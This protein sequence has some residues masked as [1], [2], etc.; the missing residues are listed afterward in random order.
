MWIPWLMAKVILR[1]FNQMLDI[2]QQNG[3]GV[4]QDK[5]PLEIYSLATLH[6][7]FAH[8]FCHKDEDILGVSFRELLNKKKIAV[9][10][11]SSGTSI[12]FK[13]ILE[14]IEMPNL[15]DSDSVSKESLGKAIANFKS[16]NIDCIFY[17][18][19]I[20]NE[21]IN[22]LAKNNDI[23]FIPLLKD[24][25]IRDMV[26]L[27]PYYSEGEIPSGLYNLGSPVDT[28]AVRA[29]LVAL[30]I[31]QRFSCSLIKSFAEK[32]DQGFPNIPPAIKDLTS[33][34]LF[35]PTGLTFLPCKTV[36][37]RVT[38]SHF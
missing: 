38:G 18:V 36:W 29:S 30:E 19:G 28:L 1:L 25:A 10:S 27:A 7:E 15:F 6:Q 5:S 33:N 35:K 21:H 17:V 9:G 23:V 8:L 16:G 34:N 26:K 3:I 24:K 11:Q 31:D 32:L 14:V 13:A 37:G 12:V 2:K 22:N 20:G 4:F